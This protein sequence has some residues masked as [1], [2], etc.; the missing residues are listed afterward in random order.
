MNEQLTS[1][2]QELESKKREFDAFMQLKGKEALIYLKKE[3]EYNKRMESELKKI[4]HKNKVKNEENFKSK[5]IVQ[6]F[7]NKMD[8][9]NNF[10]NDFQE[11]EIFQKMKQIF[12]NMGN[13]IDYSTTRFHNITLIK[14]NE[15]F[16]DYYLSANEKAKKESVLLEI[17]NKSKDKLKKESLLKFEQNAK[18]SIKQDKAAKNLERLEKE[19][20]SMNK[21]REKSRLGRPNNE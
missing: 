4:N 1:Y 18:H 5:K 20:E 10:N 6:N 19:L 3:N 8:N 9:L 2:L 16:K 7:K 11:P 15:D 21:A 13:D 17:R 12:H 14:H